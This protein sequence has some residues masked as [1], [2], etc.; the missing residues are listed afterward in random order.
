[1][2]LQLMT[3]MCGP[4]GN[5]FPGQIINANGD[6]AKALVAGRFAKPLEMAT[7]KPIKRERRESDS[8]RS[9]D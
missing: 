8:D 3:V 7:A 9:I 6:A 2:K 5:S 4:G 1:M